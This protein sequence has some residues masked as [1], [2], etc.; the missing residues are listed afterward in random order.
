MP[1]V[2]DPG[3]VSVAGPAPGCAPPYW[4]GGPPNV[5]AFVNMY[6]GPGMMTYSATMP[7]ITPFGFPPFAPSMGGTYAFPR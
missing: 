6:G 5:R 1:C 4:P 3:D 7:P 2:W